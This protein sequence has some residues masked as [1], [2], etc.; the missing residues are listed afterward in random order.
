MF[1]NGSAKN[2]ESHQDKLL[3]VG[4]P[5]GRRSSSTNRTSHGVIQILI[6]TSE[7]DRENKSTQTGTASRAQ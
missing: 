1:I 3:S 5:G 4:K 2:E 7:S 6:P